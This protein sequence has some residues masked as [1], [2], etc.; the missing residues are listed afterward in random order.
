MRRHGVLGCRLEHLHLS[1]R[2]SQRAVRLTRKISAIDDLACHVRL[3]FVHQHRADS[4]CAATVLPLMF[5][6]TF[7]V[8]RWS[9][10]GRS[11]ATDA[12][13]AAMSS[14]RGDLS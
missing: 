14:A 6:A 9:G 1:A 5:V 2:D 8:P 10:I 3:P 7:G 4:P 11:G 13:E 12:R